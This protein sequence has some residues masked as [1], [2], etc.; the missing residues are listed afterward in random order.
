MAVHAAEPDTTIPERSRHSLTH[1]ARTGILLVSPALVLVV[2]LVVVPL[3]F[4]VYISLTD[5]PLIGNFHFIGLRNYTHLN[6]DTVF[7]QVEAMTMGDR[8]AVLK[9]GRLQQVDRPKALYERP[10]NAFVAGFIGSPAM[11]LL[12]AALDSGSLRIGELQLDAVEGT[13]G[14]SGPVLVGMRPE[15]LRVSD[16]ADGIG[17][18]VTLVEELGSDAYL[19]VA[20]ELGGE[21]RTLVA[22]LLDGESA[23]HRGATVRLR[24]SAEEIHLFDADDGRRIGH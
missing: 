2:L 24:P 18:R 3:G 17:G 15:A 13:E 6:Q 11:N 16:E 23:P 9:D 22:R 12:P 19:H 8:V 20:T 21:C 14:H 4:A 1:P 7:T 10:L 5:W